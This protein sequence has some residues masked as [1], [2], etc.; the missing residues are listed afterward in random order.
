MKALLSLLLGL[1]L[2][3]SAQASPSSDDIQK[4]IVDYYSAAGADRTSP[5]MQAALEALA[6]QTRDATAPGLLLANGSFSDINYKDV[7]DGGWSPWAHTQRLFT[8][9]RAY[10]TPGQPFYGDP[11]LRGQIESGE[12]APGQQLPSVIK[13]AEQYDIAVPTVRKAISLLKA[14]GLV[15][16]VAGYGTF[17]AE[18]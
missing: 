15:T 16:G 1:L 5:R 10:R 11:Q 4:N 6:S 2:V 3:S 13:L 9:A 7:P 8:M 17:V 14:E 12:L 18:R